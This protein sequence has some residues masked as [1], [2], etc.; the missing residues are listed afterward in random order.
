MKILI[1]C[2]PTAT[3]KT[4]LAVQLARKFNGELVS[5]DSRQIYKGL[6]ALTGKERSGDVPIWLYDIVEI[7]K[8]YSAHDFVSAAEVAIANIQTRGK[9]PIVVGGTGFYLKALTA[10]IDTLSIPPNH[11]LR[12]RLASFSLEELQERLKHLD[13]TR[14]EQMNDSDRKN[15][16][17]LIRAIEVAGAKKGN[18]LQQGVSLHNATLW[19]GLTAKPQVLK[20]RIT[21]RVSERFHAA[22][23]EATK[24]TAFLLGAP[25]LLL[26]QKGEISKAEALAAWAAK[27][28]Q[29]AKRQ[30]TWFKKQNGIRWFDITQPLEDEVERMVASWYTT[31]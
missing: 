3:G 15:P 31:R 26:F 2:G 22:L 27:E 4:A 11:A 1:V 28:Y 29:Y 6:D 20:E 25:P 16:R 14:W 18:S 21:Q 5:A 17:R 12:K 30:L 7:G 24:E 9:L 13:E 19:I 23:R 10:P 8:L